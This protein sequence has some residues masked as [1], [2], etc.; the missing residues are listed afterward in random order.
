LEC[1]LLGVVLSMARGVEAA[2]IDIERGAVYSYRVA[3]NFV[4]GAVFR[5]DITWRDFILRSMSLCE[6][7]KYVVICD[8]SDCYQRIPHHRL[9][10]AL[11]Q[12]QDSGSA[13]KMIIDILTHY[14]NGRSYS[15]PAGGPAARI[16]VE[17]L[18]NLTDQL[19]RSDRIAFTRYADDYHLFV[20]SVN[21]AYEALLF[22]GEK[23]IR[24]EGLSLQKSKTRIMSSA[25]FRSSQSLVTLPEEEDINSDIRHLF[26]LNLRYDPYSATTDENYKLLKEELN[27][28]DVVGIMNR[29]LAKT[30]VHGAVTTRVVQAI[31]HLP[32]PTREG[33]VLTLVDNLDLLYPIFPVV[34]VTLKSCFHELSSSSQIEIPRVISERVIGGSFVTSTEL[35]V[36]YAVKVLSEIKTSENVDAIVSLHKK[37][38]SPL[39]RRDVILAMARWGEFAWL[40]DQ[41][42]DFQAMSA[43]DRRAFIIAS[44]SLKDAGRHWRDRT[45]KHFG[46]M[47]TLVRDWAADKSS[48]KDWVMPL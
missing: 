2:R 31:K 37:F 10:N 16:L 43:W 33:A 23:L 25:E 44:Y 45:K 13:P 6:K 9:D 28:I 7:K 22:I 11:R 17:S 1:F 18:L 42:H 5:N 29:E 34:A 47:E 40:S 27:Q 15:L 21:E 48:Q 32:N 39:V 35:H 8:I 3:A 19:L 14:S 26:S 20:D 30:R 12:I 46:M 38:S 4:D 24:N 41:M 36:A